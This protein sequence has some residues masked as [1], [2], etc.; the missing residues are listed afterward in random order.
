MPFNLKNGG[1]FNMNKCTFCGREGEFSTKNVGGYEI[2]E[3]C[4]DCEREIKEDQGDGNKTFFRTMIEEKELD[5]EV[6]HV[7]THG[8][9]HFIEMPVLINAMEN[10]SP[11]EQEF[12]EKTMRAID[13]QNGD[14]MHFINH[15]AKSYVLQN[16]S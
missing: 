16:Y 5:N 2:L 3:C 12:I 7:N 6:L 15:L 11:E 10:S 4:S 13:F 1:I 8:N 14:M 9:L